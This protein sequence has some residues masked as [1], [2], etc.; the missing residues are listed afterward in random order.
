MV[1]AVGADLDIYLLD[2]ADGQQSGRLQ[3]A[4]NGGIRCAFNHTGDLLVSTG[5]DGMVRLWDWRARQQL[6]ATYSGFTGTPRFSPDDRLMAVDVE[7]T[8]LRLWDTSGGGEYRT[9]VRNSAPGVDTPEAVA[10]R[11]DGRLLVVATNLGLSF[12]NLDTCRAAGYAPLKRRTSFAHFES[13]HSLLTY[14]E[15]GFFRRPI[16][17]G[18]GTPVTVKIGTPEKLPLPGA[19]ARAALSA[20]CRVVAICQSTGALVVDRSHPDEPVQLRHAD[21]R[22]IAVSPNGQ[23]VATGGYSHPGGAKIWEVATHKLKKDLP[24]GLL[25][26]V[27]FSPDGAWLAT[28]GGGR[29]RLWSTA[30]WTEGPTIPWSGTHIGALAFSPNSR[31]LAVETGTGAVRLIDRD[32]GALAEFEDPNQDRA[33]EVAFS[34]GGD[35]LITASRDSNSTHV[36]DLTAIRQKLAEMGLDWK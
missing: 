21:T 12:W 13:E 4:R 2:V 26:R 11:P 30:S 16:E 19:Y 35:R 6:I 27:A 20:D 7:G 18:P 33:D 25:C 23:W 22:V 24:V 36:W 10:V 1:A 31:M 28:T 9:L 17:A 5:W 29:P 8:K 14:G 32:G 15:D 34:P 3:G